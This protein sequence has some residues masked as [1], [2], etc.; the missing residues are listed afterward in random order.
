VP[1]RKV[2]LERIPLA[3]VIANSVAILAIQRAKTSIKT[4]WGEIQAK[5][6]DVCW[7]QRVQT[8]NQFWPAFDAFHALR[9]N[10]EMQHLREGVNARVS[11]TRNSHCE[12]IG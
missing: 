8:R 3:V 2:C 12:V 10:V 4:G 7:Q 1:K 6:S 9:R 11:S 5:Y